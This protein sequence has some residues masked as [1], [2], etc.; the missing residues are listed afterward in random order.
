MKLE[1]DLTQDEINMIAYDLREIGNRRHEQALDRKSHDLR[2]VGDAHF[3]L[4]NRLTN[5]SRLKGGV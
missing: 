4:A 2:R 5:Q 1:I 3:R